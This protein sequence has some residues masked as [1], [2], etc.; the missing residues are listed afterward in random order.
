MR[1]LAP[2]LEP[3]G[4]GA[5]G[6]AALKLKRSLG[7]GTNKLHPGHCVDASANIVLF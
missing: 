4:C 1:L 2:L 7:K 6:V 3:Q 5:S